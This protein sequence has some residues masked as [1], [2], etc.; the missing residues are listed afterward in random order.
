MSRSHARIHWLVDSYYLEDL[1]S[2]NG[3]FVRVETEAPVPSGGK[4]RIG[5]Q[6]FSLSE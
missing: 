5:S 1:G 6:L 3:S 4:L 2:R